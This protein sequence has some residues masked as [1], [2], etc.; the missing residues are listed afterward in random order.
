M[1]AMGKGSVLLIDEMVLPDTHVDWQVTS[2]D[3]SMMCAF[4]ARERTETQWLELLASVG[5][6]LVKKLI[7][8]PAVYE[9]V[10]ETI[11]V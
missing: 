9:S 4:G 2:I 5:L 8:K 1:N 10:M 6:K 11:P 3:L 7:Y